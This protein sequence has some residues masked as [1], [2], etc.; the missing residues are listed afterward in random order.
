MIV[1]IVWKIIAVFIYMFIVF[2]IDGFYS[3]ASESNYSEQLFKNDYM[4][5]LILSQNFNR[6]FFKAAS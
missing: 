1:L 2:N 3:A 5:V 6:F 4:N